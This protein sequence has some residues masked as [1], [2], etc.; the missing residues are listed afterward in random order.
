M[1][2]V[3][4][5]IMPSIIITGIGNVELAHEFGK[6]AFWRLYQQMKVVGHEDITEKLDRVDIYRLDEDL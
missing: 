3:P 1:V 2:Q 4:H 5:A 6:I